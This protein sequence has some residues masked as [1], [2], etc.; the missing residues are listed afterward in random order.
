[1]PAVS[2]ALSRARALSLSH[3]HARSL[4]VLALSSRHLTL[5]LSLSPLFNPLPSF[6]TA[7]RRTIKYIGRPGAGKVERGGCPTPPPAVA[8]P[9]PHPPAGGSAVG[10]TVA[11]ASGPSESPPPPPRQT[12]TPGFSSP[13]TSGRSE[14]QKKLQRELDDF[15][16]E[17]ADINRVEHEVSILA[18]NS[19]SIEGHKPG[20][21]KQIQAISTPSSS[22][23]HSAIE[24]VTKQLHRIAASPKQSRFEAAPPKGVTL[25]KP[26]LLVESTK[27][28]NDDFGELTIHAP[29]SLRASSMSP[30]DGKRSAFFLPTRL[31]PSVV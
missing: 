22:Y 21:L 24:E 30:T 1:M 7:Q 9:T 15:E 19:P 26:V 23:G 29:S 25:T 13:N 5:L 10:S 18:F 12:P 6:S 31:P 17:L 3:T 11:V 16:Q 8:R 27:R 14:A 2:L 4:C 20:D 28:G